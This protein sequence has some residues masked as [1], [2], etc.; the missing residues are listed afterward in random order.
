[1]LPSD[2]NLSS[3]VHKSMCLLVSCYYVFKL[4][5]YAEKLQLLNSIKT[6]KNHRNNNSLIKQ[7]VMS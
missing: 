5:V 3:K 7:F 4:H 6:A 2:M 1:M